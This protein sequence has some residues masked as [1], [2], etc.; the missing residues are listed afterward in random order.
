MENSNLIFEVFIRMRKANYFEIFRNTQ[1]IIL[2]F[3]EPKK[4]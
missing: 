2:T 4:Y 1:Q 3:G